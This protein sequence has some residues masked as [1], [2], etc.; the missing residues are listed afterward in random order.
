M[1]KASVKGSG[2]IVILQIKASY[3]GSSWQ[4]TSTEFLHP[5][6]IC[7]SD[8]QGG[9]ELTLLFCCEL[10]SRSKHLL[11]PFFTVIL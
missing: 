6:D 3:G 4:L 7:L 5:E 10:T 2:Q 9:P 11:C 1:T 8:I